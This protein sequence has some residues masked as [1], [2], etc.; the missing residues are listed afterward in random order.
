MAKTMD[1]IRETEERDDDDDDFIFI[2]LIEYA[3]F[4]LSWQI[5]HGD[6]FPIISVT[7]SPVKLN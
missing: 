4:F 6:N 5:K 3:I 2:L 1:A 7:C